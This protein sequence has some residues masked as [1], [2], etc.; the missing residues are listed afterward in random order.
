MKQKFKIKFFVFL[1]F[2]FCLNTN[3]FSQENFAPLKLIADTN[4]PVKAISFSQN[5]NQYA[6]AISDTI[7][8]CNSHTDEVEKVILGHTGQIQQISMFDYNEI[9]LSEVDLSSENSISENNE[10]TSS[11]TT[12]TEIQKQI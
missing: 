12:F 2:I 4:Y 3:L 9:S 1:L 10:Q 5:Q 7:I 11:D 8:I 6:Y